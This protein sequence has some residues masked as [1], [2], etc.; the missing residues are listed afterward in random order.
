MGDDDLVIRISAV[1]TELVGAVTEAKVALAGLAAQSKAGN[2]AALGHAAALNK[3]A[4]MADRLGGRLWSFLRGA[5]NAFLRWAKRGALVFLGL[6]AAI[7]ALGVKLAVANQRF[8]IGAT[9]ML[10]SASAAKRLNA[11]LMKLSE[12]TPFTMKNLRP[13]AGT[14]IAQPGIKRKNVIPIMSAIGDVVAATGGNDATLSRVM[15][16][17]TQ[18]IARRAIG[19]REVRSF[20]MN[21]I[22]AAAQFAAT[23]KTTPE[24]I[25]ELMSKQGGGAVLFRKLGGAQGVAESL[26]GGRFK[27]AAKEL[28][29]KSLGGIASNIQDAF[30]NGLT[31]AFDALIPIAMPALNRFQKALSPWM[32]RFGRNFGVAIQRFMGGKTGA[33]S[34]RLA[35]A[36]GLGD[37]AAGVF[38]TVADAISGLF[39]LIRRNWP[40]IVATVAIF[41]D[42]GK[43]LTKFLLPVALDIAATVVPA[44]VGVVFVLSK[45]LQ[46]LRPLNVVLAPF[47]VSLGAM[48]LAAKVVKVVNDLKVAMTALNVV[49]R[50]N[51]W[52]LVAA[53]IA[54]V[55]T[56]LVVLYRHSATFRH[57]VQVA[58]RTAVYAFH[59]FLQSIKAVWHWLGRVVDR[60]A[61]VGHALA[62][63]ANPLTGITNLGGVIARNVIPGGGDTTRPRAFAGTMAALGG[64]AAL[65]GGQFAVTSGV[66]DTG[67]GYAGSRHQSGHAVDV[68]G[69]HLGALVGNWNASGGYGAVHGAGTGRHAHLERPA[70]D[71]TRPRANG[72]LGGV[73]QIVV[74]ID[75][76]GSDLTAAQIEAAAR[77]GTQSAIGEYVRNGYERTV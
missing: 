5:G 69:S 38:K 10:G 30:E 55:I 23:L 76:R 19:A 45:M 34:A 67:L 8:L 24:A 3:V 1:T 25:M 44:F 48:L 12:S 27:G 51:P 63:F 50:N 4:S 54:L 11:D 65:T 33:G 43:N 35:T 57:I 53:A 75:A 74:H 73:P 31:R 16:E 37:G 68:T 56:G 64:V 70:G 40:L 62:R 9:R 6:G 41:V 52:I 7:G 13:L 66:R 14:L 17:L 39:G 22:P 36:F 26:G 46:V 18:I 58:G 28:S 2:V 49:M 71:T 29:T 72:G 59:N 15:L 32:A 21:R 61:K 47:I 20:S 77:R 60:A 42:F